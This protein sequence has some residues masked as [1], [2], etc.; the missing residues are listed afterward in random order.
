MFLGKEAEGDWS[1]EESEESEEEVDV[2]VEPK[3]VTEEGAG[4]VVEK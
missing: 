1:E 4:E 2:E 3:E